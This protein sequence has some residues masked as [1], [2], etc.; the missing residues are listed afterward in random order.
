METAHLRPSKDGYAPKPALEQLP[1]PGRQILEGRV[2]ARRDIPKVHEDAGTSFAS[3]PG[4]DGRDQ[5][6]Q[7]GLESL[8]ILDPGVGTAQPNEPLLVEMRFV[9][10]I[11][12]EGPHAFECS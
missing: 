8:E 6:A 9:I 1:I 10:L 11:G 4:R 7:G 2:I 12:V 3:E 5:P